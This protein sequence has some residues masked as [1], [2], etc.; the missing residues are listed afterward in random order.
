MYS[1][2]TGNADAGDSF[3]SFKTAVEFFAGPM[4]Y[5]EFRKTEVWIGGLTCV[6]TEIFNPLSSHHGVPAVALAAGL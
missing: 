3:S 6:V 4:G 1:G 5:G 2:F